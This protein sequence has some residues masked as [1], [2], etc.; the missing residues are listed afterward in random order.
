MKKLFTLLAF[1]AFLAAGTLTA[2]A[3]DNAASDDA[4]APDGQHHHWGAFD[5]LPKDDAQ[6]IRDTMQKAHEDS[7][8]LMSQSKKLRQDLRAI[9]TADQFDEKAFIATQAKMQAI[10]NKIKAKTT[11][12]FAS[13]LAQLPAAD[14][15]IIADG[16]AKHPWGHD[17]GHWHKASEHADTSQPA[18]AANSH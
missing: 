2:N 6:L 17:K 14:R 7:K 13:A 16:M 5:K 10:K 18:L 4:N 3:N 9:L 12:A 1:T 15:K 8:D 11:A